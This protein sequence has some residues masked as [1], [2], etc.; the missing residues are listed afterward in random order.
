M[1]ENRQSAHKKSTKPLP[2]RPTIGFLT[3]NLGDVTQPIAAAIWRGMANVAQEQDFNLVCFAGGVLRSERGFEAQANVL[4]NLVNPEHYDGL[5]IWASIL[6]WHVDETIKDFYARYRP[7][8]MVSLGRSLDGMPSLLIDNYQGIHNVLAHLIE[9]HHCRR[10]AFIRG[11]QDY[12]EAEERYQTYVDTLAEY[13]LPLDMNLVIEAD[14]NRSENRALINCLLDERQVDFDAVAAHNDDMAITALAELQARGIRVPDDVAVVGL[15]DILEARAVTPPLTT[16]GYLYDEYGRQAAEMLL[17]LLAGENVAEE[18]YLSGNL[19]VRQSCGCL[20]PVVEQA[21][22]GPTMDLF[23][24]EFTPEAL[25]IALAPQQ[26]DIVSKMMLAIIGVLPHTKTMPDR[27]WANLLFEKFLTE[28]IV[29]SPGVFLQALAEV[30]R[31]IIAS[32]GDAITD[33]GQKVMA[34]QGTISALRRHTRPYLGNGEVLAWAENLWRQARVMIGETAQR[35][36]AHQTLQAEQQARALREI[37]QTLIT[38]FDMNELMDILARE[39]P[40]LGIT[41]CYLSLYENPDKPA[42]LSR[43]ILAYH[44]PGRI[45]LETGKQCFSSPQLTPAGMLPQNERYTLVVE[46]LY[47]RHEQL[48]F[49]LFAEGPREGM[50]YGVL[51]G[52]ISSALQGALLVKRRRQAEEAMARRVSELEL[53]AQV[54]VAASTILNPTELLQRV[55]DLTKESFDLY[56]AHIYLVDETETML[57]LT[58]GAGTVGQRM[59]AEGWRIPLRREQSL[60]ARAAW[61]RQGIIVNNVRQDP[62]WLPHP[63][64]PDTQAELAVPLMAGDRVLGV[65]D[66]QADEPDYFTVDDIRIQGTLAAQ[67]TAAL[68]NARL[69]EQS[70]KNLTFTERLYQAGRQIMAASDLPEIVAAVAEV[71]PTGNINRLVLLEF[72]YNARAELEGMVVRANWHSG[73]GMPPTP[74]GAR[75]RRR[76][77]PGIKEFVGAEPLIFEDVQHDQRFDEELQ[78]TFRQLNIWAMAALPL[79]AGTRQRGVLLLQA[80]NVYQL[81]ETEIRP[82]ISLMGQVAV[83]VEN[84]R[85]L[86]ETKAALA[87][88]A[89]VQQR[90]TVQNWEAYRA[91]S[92]A[93]SYEHI[94][95][96]AAL[97][98]SQLPAPDGQ[99]RLMDNNQ[100]LLSSQQPEEAPFKLTAPL[101]IR[102]EVVG[103]LGLDEFYEREWTQD[104]VTLVKAISEQ[105][106]QAYENLRLIDETQQRAAREARI[107][108]IGEKIREAQ[109][110][111]EALQITIREVGASLE[112]HQTAVKLELSDS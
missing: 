82:Y 102:D 1:I 49:V 101:T 13:G 56:H 94:R 8:P 9:V 10:I 81:S 53:V 28:L 80:Q 74:I 79:W 83:A 59:V 38:T 34:W 64:L 54:S 39:L 63:L 52:Q 33:V 46:P 20:D 100:S 97:S 6:P 96:G 2:Y 37:S 62:G 45:T 32:G 106:A 69:F 4:Y 66:V 26:E 72:E 76:M 24:G 50:V 27:D 40:Q 78:T 5:I 95:E 65:L 109:S 68:E 29:K 41:R 31:Q 110:L 73:Q 19:V 44:E 112:T 22:A 103:I 105:L 77:F 18:V 47:F 15:E 14:L 58:A 88:V 51:Q 61:T 108:E 87:E 67:V 55:A 35:V 91:K 30:L 85:L 21:V 25:E 75:Y 42:E 7:L 104:E 92:V 71:A 36:E 57:V 86:A 89:A 17:A 90:Y 107:S 3:P 93:Q 11:P 60:V 111:E 12:Q 70:Q 98:V 43:L 48:G 84:Q 99:Q 23:Q 16:A